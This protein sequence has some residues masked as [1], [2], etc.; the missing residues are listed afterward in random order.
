MLQFALDLKTT[1][2]LVAFLSSACWV[3]SLPLKCGQTTTDVDSLKTAIFEELQCSD[4]EEQNGNSV[5]VKKITVGC[6]ATV[7]A[8]RDAF[9]TKMEVNTNLTVDNASCTWMV[10]DG[11]G[12]RMATLSRE[13]TRDDFYGLILFEMKE[14]KLL[15]NSSI[16]LMGLASANISYECKYKDQVEKKTSRVLVH[17]GPRIFSG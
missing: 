6:N 9:I 16:T 11:F 10:D 13:S 14:E 7:N 17:G 12:D 3:K 4:H 15:I 1:Y 2:F 5:E 8:I